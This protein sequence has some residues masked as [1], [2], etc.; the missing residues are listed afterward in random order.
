MI[1]CGR[2]LNGAGHTL[3]DLIVVA[4]DQLLYLATMLVSAKYI[5]SRWI[6]TLGTSHRFG[7]NLRV[8]FL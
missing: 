2:S 4:I 1:S 7:M 8:D 6:R 3:A 5:E